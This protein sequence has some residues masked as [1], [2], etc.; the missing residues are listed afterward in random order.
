VAEGIISFEP[1]CRAFETR[2]FPR[3]KVQDFRFISFALGIA[4]VHP[5]EDLG[6][7]LRFGP[8]RA[9]VDGQNGV[10]DVIGLEKEHLKF[11]LSEALAESGQALLEF[12]VDVFAL[13]R[14]FEQD[15]EFLL[16][17]MEAR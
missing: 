2:F 6:P 5:E 14:Q 15:I 8:S 13:P 16:F 3:L 4:Q 11:G 1:Q 17:L 7:V 12:P 9:G 10:A